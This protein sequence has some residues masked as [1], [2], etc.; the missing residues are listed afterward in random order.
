MQWYTE[1]ECC[2]VLVYSNWGRVYSPLCPEHILSSHLYPKRYHESDRFP[3]A[4]YL[5]KQVIVDYINMYNHGGILTVMRHSKF[6][7]CYCRTES[8]YSSL[9]KPLQVYFQ[10]K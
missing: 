4:I 8:Y 9:N 6:T 3:Q 10:H 7:D 2:W 1:E 5:P